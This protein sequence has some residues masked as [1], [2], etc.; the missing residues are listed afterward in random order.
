MSELKL[1]VWEN[2]FQDYTNGIAFAIASN[3][4]EAI[5]LALGKEVLMDWMVEELEETK[6]EI[7]PLDKPYGNYVNG[8]G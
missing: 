7:L 6:P 8:G 1:Y 5:K 4:Q 2:V 3:K